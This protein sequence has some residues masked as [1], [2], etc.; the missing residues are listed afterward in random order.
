MRD[1]QLP[2][3]NQLE[4]RRKELTVALNEL[5]NDLAQRGR[6]LAAAADAPEL[7]ACVRKTLAD[8]SNAANGW[9]LMSETISDCWGV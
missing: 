5:S 3:P 4:L 9:E 8:L 6:D 2:D 7:A 1:P